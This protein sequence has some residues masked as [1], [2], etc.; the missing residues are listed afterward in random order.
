MGFTMTFP[1]LKPLNNPFM[2]PSFFF[3]F[4]NDFTFTFMASIPLHDSTREKKNLIIIKTQ[5]TN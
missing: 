2:S 1:Y 4:S 5:A 3:L